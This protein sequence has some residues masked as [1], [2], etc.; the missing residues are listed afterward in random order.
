MDDD[1]DFYKSFYDFM[2]SSMRDDDDDDDDINNGNDYFEYDDDD[3]YPSLERPQ[4]SFF[5]SST[6][7]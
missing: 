4:T 7:S 3:H 6:L 2:T 5:Y 1:S